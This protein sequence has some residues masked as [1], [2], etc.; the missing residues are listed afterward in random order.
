M[1]ELLELVLSTLGKTR[2]EF[3]AE[4]EVAKKESSVENIGNLLAILMQNADFTA[5]II[6]KLIQEV[7]MLKER[8]AELEGS[9]QS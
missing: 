2:A 7:D 6:S 8:I 5:N 3:E 4:V 1:D 9:T